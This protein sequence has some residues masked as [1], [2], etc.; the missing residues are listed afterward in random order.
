VY[1]G[2]A[3][4]SSC[5]EFQSRFGGQLA[6]Y[7]RRL[8]CRCESCRILQQG[9]SPDDYHCVLTIEAGDWKATKVVF[10]SALTIAATKEKKATAKAK[11]AAATAQKVARLAADAA[12]FQGHVEGAPNPQAAVAAADLTDGATAPQT[13]ANGLSAAAPLVANAAFAAAYSAEDARQVAASR[14]ETAFLYRCAE[15]EEE[16]SSDEHEED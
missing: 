9:G 8:P 15:R 13:G 5:F 11:R 2:V 1:S 7:H 16:G 4:S 12:A 3:G 10:K 6:I 14:G